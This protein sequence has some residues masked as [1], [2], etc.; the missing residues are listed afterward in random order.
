MF[1]KKLL[2][3]II[4]ISAATNAVTIYAQTTSPA[5]VSDIGEF[6]GSVGYV[7][8]AGS[9]VINAEIGRWDTPY[10]GEGYPMPGVEPEGQSLLYIQIDCLLYLNNPHS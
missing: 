4:F 2:E 10:T 9:T 7:T 6:S 8:Y 3:T 5:V 1:K